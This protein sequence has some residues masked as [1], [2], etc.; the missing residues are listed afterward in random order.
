[1]SSCRR[2]WK[3]WPLSARCVLLAMAGLSAKPACTVEMCVPIAG[4]RT[5][6]GD[7]MEKATPNSEKARGWILSVGSRCPRL[8]KRNAESRSLRTAVLAMLEDG[9]SPEEIVIG[10]ECRLSEVLVVWRSWAAWAAN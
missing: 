9:F 10:L 5:W 8:R 7:G 3:L 6:T 2:R 4:M 1:M